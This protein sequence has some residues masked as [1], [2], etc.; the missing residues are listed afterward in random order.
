MPHNLYLHSSL[1]QTRLIGSSDDDKK[2][3]IKYN[4]IDT[5]IALSIA[6]FVNGAILL[7]AASVFHSHGYTS[8]VDIHDAYKML[9][10]LL[11][12]RLAPIL[13]AI[14]LIIAGQSSTITGTLAGQ[15][16][17]E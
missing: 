3:A 17:M 7:V 9:E 11:G 14:A 13:F 8:I 6:L 1:V 16:V 15:I 5:L 12:N 2:Q 4:L 10:Q